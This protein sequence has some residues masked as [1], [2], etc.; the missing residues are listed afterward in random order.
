MALKTAVSGALKRAASNLGDGFGLSLY[1]GGSME[2]LVKRVVGY[3]TAEGQP[4][5]TP[6]PPETTPADKAD[7][8]WVQQAM[9]ETP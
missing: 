5:W 8:E 1:R 9:Q 4:G 6:A 7:H 2:P 3:N